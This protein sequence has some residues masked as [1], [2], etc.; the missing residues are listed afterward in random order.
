M[1]YKIY[2]VTDPVGGELDFVIL[3]SKILPADINCLLCTSADD[4]KHTQSILKRIYFNSRNSLVRNFIKLIYPFFGPRIKDNDSVI[5][6]TPGSLVPRGKNITVYIHAPPR[7][8]ADMYKTYRESLRKRNMLL[9]YTIPFIRYLYNALFK[10]SVLNAGS[11]LCNSE[12]TK[13]RLK[14]YYN[15][16]AK[17]V[18][19]PVETNKF[20]NNG[21]EQY[22]LAVSRIIPP[23]N[24][25]FILKAFK[26]FTDTNRNFKLIIAGALSDED[27][28]SLYLKE[29]KEYVNANMLNVEFYLNC[30]EDELIKLY[31]G[32]Y[33]FLFAADEEDFGLVI[34]EA[35]AS[36]K[37]VISINSGGPREIIQNGITGFLVNSE[38]EMADKMDYLV[39]N[40]EALEAMGKAAR[41]YVVNN[42]SVDDFKKKLLN[43]IRDSKG[44]E[45]HAGV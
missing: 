13:G 42:I 15:I 5:F 36:S 37:P 40:F 19:R 22:F 8:F 26:T 29:L 6:S 33:C 31:S 27:A 24:F 1:K 17:I 38:I 23:K 14:K 7:I 25:I 30:N 41:D 10:I 20:Y 12:T 21:Y 28:S 9:F 45:N 16:D 2:L 35:M 34:L 18:Y 4:D 39:R 32:A 43:E 11:I 44:G 3:I